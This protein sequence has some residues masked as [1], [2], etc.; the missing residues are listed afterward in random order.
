MGLLYLIRRCPL[1]GEL[2]GEWELEIMNG[3]MTYKKKG[4]KDSRI[5]PLPLLLLYPRAFKFD[6]S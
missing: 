2:R 5:K 3:S 1:V 4:T 6:V